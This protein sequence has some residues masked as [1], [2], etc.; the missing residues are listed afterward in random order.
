MQFRGASSLVAGNCLHACL[1]S[2]L[3]FPTSKTW[4]LL[5]LRAV[6]LYAVNH[7]LDNLLSEC[8]TRVDVAAEVNSGPNARLSRFGCLRLERSGI[9]RKQVSERTRVSSRDASVDGPST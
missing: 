7:S 9:V 4:I 5:S 8:Q 6:L 1:D 2:H 3:E